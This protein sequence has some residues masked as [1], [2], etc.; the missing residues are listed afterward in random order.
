MYPRKHGYQLLLPHFVGSV[1]YF[2]YEKVKLASSTPN[3]C[4]IVLALIRLFWYRYILSHVCANN[5]NFHRN[6]WQIVRW[7]NDQFNHLHIHHVQLFISTVQKNVSLKITKIQNRKFI[8]FL[9][10]IRFISNFHCSIRNV[11]LVLLNERKSGPEF[12]K[13]VK[14]F[15]LKIN[16]I[17]N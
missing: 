6:T 16:N 15:V 13:L 7:W 10:F 11:L 2:S 3:K 12:G 9:I 5:E 4:R 17:I 8:S 1:P 14:T